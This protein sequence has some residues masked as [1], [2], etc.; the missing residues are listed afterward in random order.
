MQRGGFLGILENVY[1]LGL[2]K[3]VELFAPYCIVY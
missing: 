2:K 3:P 1:I